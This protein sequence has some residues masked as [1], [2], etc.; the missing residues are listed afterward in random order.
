MVR[1]SQECPFLQDEGDGQPS[2]V[3]SQ[4][5]RSLELLK[6]IVQVDTVIAGFLV[7]SLI[8]RNHEKVT[9]NDEKVQVILQVVTA[10]VFLAA[11]AHTVVLM[12]CTGWRYTLAWYDPLFPAGFSA[13]GMIL[14]Y[15]TIADAI[16]LQLR[17]DED[18]DTVGYWMIII[19]GLMFP[20][21]LA[22]PTAIL[23]MVLHK[24]ERN[25]RNSRVDSLG[26]SRVSAPAL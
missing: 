3:C 23:Q 13:I 2:A 20:M 15:F 12:V 4:H 25:D 22:G 7:L 24:F 11:I 14:L 19:F 16:L 1:F 9:R 21:G 5:V 8:G 26:T 18:V 17:P 6:T 10:S